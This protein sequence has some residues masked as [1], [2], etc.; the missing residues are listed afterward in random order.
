MKPI[1]LTFTRWIAA[2]C[3]VQQHPYVCVGFKSKTIVS[4]SVL[5][6]SYL[7]YMQ[8]R[9]EPVISLRPWR[10]YMRRLWPM[11]GQSGETYYLWIQP[12]LMM[13]RVVGIPVND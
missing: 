6:H 8:D 7:E 3:D 10:A 2:C 13:R 1:T 9:G 5:I 11:K 4:E 12:K